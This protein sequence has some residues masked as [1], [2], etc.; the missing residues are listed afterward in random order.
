MVGPQQAAGARLGSM[1]AAG[2][3]SVVVSA[4]VRSVMQPAGG[5]S[6]G[7]GVRGWRVQV[8][9]GRMSA[10]MGLAGV[11]CGR[12]RPG[13][14]LLGDIDAAESDSGTVVASWRPWRNRRRKVAAP[15]HFLSVHFN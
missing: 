7:A 4:V 15:L 5:R 10:A 3:M 11:E 6:G 2:A 14:A 8:V 13:V 9:L 12:F 1:A